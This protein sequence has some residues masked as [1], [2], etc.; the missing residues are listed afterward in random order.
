MKASNNKEDFN[1]T[2]DVVKRRIKE[3]NFNIK[4][5]ECEAQGISK[6][7]CYLAESQH[8]EA[9]NNASYNAAYANARD[10]AAGTG[11]WAKNSKKHHHDD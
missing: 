8:K 11:V 6:D 10:A 4:A 5:T 1:K 9:I 2:R 3:G 7:T